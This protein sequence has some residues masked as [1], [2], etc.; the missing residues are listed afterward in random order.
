VLFLD[1]CCGTKSAGYGFRSLGWDYIGLDNDAELEPDILADVRDFNWVGDR[2]PDFIWAS[3]PCT[4]FS[5]NSMPW[6]HHSPPDLSIYEAC[7]RIINEV[8]PMY[9][10]IENVR[11]AVPYFRGTP[12]V[13][14]PYYLWTN[15][16]PLPRFSLRAGWKPKSIRGHGLVRAIIPRELSMTIAAIA[17][18]QSK[19]L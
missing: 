17:S 11:G 7:C 1:L 6:L 4:E 2:H 14:D 8:R 12:Q 13:I 15:L 3:P 9:Y 16:P 5:Q 18:C 19:L 10:C